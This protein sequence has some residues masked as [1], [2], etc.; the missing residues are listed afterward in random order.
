MD[1]PL[2]LKSGRA[3]RRR[4]ERRRDLRGSQRGGPVPAP[5]VCQSPRAGRG[6][7]RHGQDRDAA[8]HRGGFLGLRRAGL[9]GRREGRS[10]GRQPGRR[11]QSAGARARRAARH[12]GLC[13][14][15]L[16]DGLLGPVRRE[17]PPHPHDGERSRAGVAGP[18]A[19][20]QRDAGRR[21]QHR[22]QNRGRSGPPAARLQ[23][24]PGAAAMGRRECRHAHDRVRQCQQAISRHDPAPA[25]DA[26]PAGR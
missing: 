12:R 2:W 15:R 21:A 10:L 1:R 13:G 20:A 5:E 9:H 11:Q 7:H 18:P 8:D 23:G 22:L 16:P 6:R 4:H 25:P 26:Q 24:S 19:A 17:G 14:P 3:H